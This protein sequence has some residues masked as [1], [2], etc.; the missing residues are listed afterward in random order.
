MHGHQIP[1]ATAD[2]STM[3]RHPYL[4]GERQVLEGVHAEA[5]NGRELLAEELRQSAWVP[6]EPQHLLGCFCDHLVQGEGLD[7]C[8]AVVAYKHALAGEQLG[9]SKLDKPPLCITQRRVDFV[10]L[11]QRQWWHQLLSLSSSRSLFIPLHLDFP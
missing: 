11:W 3:Q 4:P 1:V 9:F 10:D 2:R 6:R 5:C 7:S 8:V